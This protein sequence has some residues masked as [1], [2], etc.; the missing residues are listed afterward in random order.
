[1]PGFMGKQLDEQKGKLN[2]VVATWSLTMTE[3]IFLSIPVL[4]S[5]SGYNRFAESFRHSL[6][7]LGFER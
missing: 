3:L 6:A 7:A 2:Y 1:M 4:V 5:D